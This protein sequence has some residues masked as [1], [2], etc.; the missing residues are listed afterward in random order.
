MRHLKIIVVLLASAAASHAQTISWTA[1]TNPHVVNGNYTVPPGTT[2]V[3][4]PGAVVNITSSSTLQVDGQL[5]ANG[6][7]ANWVPITGA[8]NFSSLLN[9]TGT[10]NLGFTNVR[11]QV[12]PYQNR[13][14]LFADCTFSAN[15]TIFNNA[16]QDAGRAPYLQFDRCAF[17]GNGTNQSSS[18][19]LA[20]ATMVLRNTSFTNGAYCSLYPA[21]LY[22]DQVSSDRSSNFGLIVTRCSNNYE[23][24]QL[25]EKLI[26]LRIIKAMR[27]EPLRSMATAKTCAIGSMSRIIARAS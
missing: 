6:T 3:L 11:T 18:L 16:V 7:A 25:P 9:V 27:D 15:G 8:T 14:L 5:I 22:L 2:L 26:P 17:Q 20:Y 10:A 4:E 12:R 19:Y 21:Y 23:P 1:A 24:Y 13:S